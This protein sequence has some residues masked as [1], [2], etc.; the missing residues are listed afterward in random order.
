MDATQK[1]L[2]GDDLFNPLLSMG[3]QASFILSVSHFLQILLKPLRQPTPIAQLCAGMLL[4]HSFLSRIKVVESYFFQSSAADYYEVMAFFGRI[5]IMFLIGLQ[6]DLSFLRRNLRTIFLISSAGT[7]ICFIF[8]GAISYPFF[9]FYVK[10]GNTHKG[11]R[12][13]SFVVLLMVAMANSASPLVDRFASELNIGSSHFGRLVVCSSLMNDVA[14]LI[15]GPVVRKTGTPGAYSIGNWF[16]SV[17][18]TAIVSV[19]MRYLAGWL[20]GWQNRNRRYMKNAQFGSVF[21]VVVFTAGLT[22]IMGENS[23]LSSFLL[24]VTFPREGRTTR[25]LMSKL[26]YVVYTFVLPIYFGYIGFQANLKLL[27][28]LKDLIGIIVILSLCIGGKI[29]GT[30]S[31]CSRLN[32]PTNKALA[33]SL[34]LNLKGHYDMLIIGRA[35]LNADWSDGFYNIMV[36]T[37]LLNTLLSGIPVAIFVWKNNKTFGYHPIPLEFRAPESELRVLSCV[38]NARSVPTMVSLIGGLGWSRELPVTAYLTHLIEL[39]PKKRASSK[40]YHQ[41]EDDELSDDEAYGGNEALEIS[42]IVDTFVSDTGIFIS[43]LKAVSPMTRIY[44]DVCHSTEE[45]RASIVVLPYHKH[46]RIDGKMETG[47]DGLRTTNQRVLRQ[48]PCAVGILVDR[49]LFGNSQSM[50]HIA[51]LF[52]GGPDDREALSFSRRIGMQAHVNLTVIRFLQNN[53]ESHE[54]INVSLQRDEEVFMAMPSRAVEDEADHVSLEEFY[55]RHVTSGQAG[56]VER[57]VK[58]GA[59][60]AMALRELVDTYQLFIVGR[61]GR[62]NTPITTAMSDWEECPELG[63]V[64]DLLASSDCGTNNSVLIIQQCRPSS[65]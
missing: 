9:R 7:L 41:M 22:E 63:T 10:Q 11:E 37:V 42:D 24:G 36:V 44:E 29:L 34:L 8:A 59:E 3:L 15:L 23:I 56:Y 32:I 26:S 62:Q 52:F 5:V 49:G 30:F 25:T 4:G 12:F 19:F 18:V 40:M 13:P 54:R 31:V 45:V 6:L 14:S 47:K 50:Q 35:K 17:L 61:G 38:Y 58:N 48:A 28:N 1:I 65:D 55:N 20:N 2:C 46:Q 53:R 33:L 16:A 21:I 43:Q 64:G 57:H 51:V 60:T 39:L 27:W